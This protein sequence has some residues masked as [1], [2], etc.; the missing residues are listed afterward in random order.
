MLSGFKSPCA[1]SWS[2]NH[3]P[4]FSKYKYAYIDDDRDNVISID[5]ITVQNRKQH[6]YYCI[7][8][9]K[10]LLPR[11]INSKCRKPHFYHK[12]EVSC[13]VETYLHKLT[14][15]VLKRKFDDNPTFSVEYV[16]SK[17]CSNNSCKYKNSRCREESSPY[18]IDLKKY[19]DTC[20]IEKRINN[21]VADL[22][23]TNS[24]KPNT[25]P[26]L[27]EVCVNHP[28]SEVKRNSGL[29]IIEIK[30]WLKKI[31]IKK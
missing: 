11:A 5:E 23:L 7:G 15:H 28:C 16:I 17:E 10:E 12:E 25:K 1:N 20:T 30:I 6:K 27:I 24:K 14:K 3:L 22:L 13:S 9:G 21:F 26:T 29:R 18:K 4:S 31:N 8:C 2:F 19:Y